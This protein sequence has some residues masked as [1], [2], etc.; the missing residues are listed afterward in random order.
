ML[1]IS[2]ILLILSA[3][4]WFCEAPLVPTIRL[5]RNGAHAYFF[6]SQEADKFGLIPNDILGF[7][8][9][10]VFDGSNDVVVNCHGRDIDPITLET[11]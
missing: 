11:Y 2:I 4:L 9:G 3:Y 8:K 1:I 10:T 7:R 5:T 6:T